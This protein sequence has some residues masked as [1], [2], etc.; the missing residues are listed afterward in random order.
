MYFAYI[1]EQQVVVALA[2]IPLGAASFGLQFSRKS[3]D[4]DVNND[5]D[6]M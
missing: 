1:E 5:H 4:D 3:A 6:D 2:P